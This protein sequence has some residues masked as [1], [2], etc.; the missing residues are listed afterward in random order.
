MKS[1]WRGLMAGACVW[2]ALH[3]PVAFAQAFPA[4][5]VR[6]VSPFPVGSGPDVALRLVAEKLAGYWHQ[7]V[8]VENKTGGNGV[9]GLQAAKSGGSDGHTLV[10]TDVS[11]ATINQNLLKQWPFDMERDFDAVATMFRTPF[12]VATS[13]ASGYKSVTDLVSGAR[14]AQPPLAYAI[15][16]VGSPNHLG[17]V[18]LAKDIQVE[19]VPVPFRETSQLFAAVSTGE[20]AW[21]FGSVATARPFVEQ[22]KLKFLAV[23]ARQRAAAYPEVPTLKEAGG[24]ADL[25]V[26]AWVG[27]FVPKG[28]PQAVLEKINQDVQRAIQEPDVKA[29]F[30]GVGLDPLHLGL[31]DFA[32][33][34]RTDI[35][36]F[37]TV[38][39]ASNLRVE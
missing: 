27:L 30:V 1:I 2:V 22:G 39:E 21:T 15:P 37:A 20:V 4:K 6:I 29:R 26:D 33:L 24:P 16:W 10:M 14:K 36:R 3:A 9:I 35:Q 13:A 19:M 32:E 12:F 5:P 34:V 31:T 38:I 17:A 28:A 23:A 25:D 18:A 11:I 7:P 8:T